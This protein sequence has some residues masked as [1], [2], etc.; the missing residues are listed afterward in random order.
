MPVVSSF[1][2]IIITMFW[3]EH[4][5]PPFHVSYGEYKAILL[6]NGYTLVQGWLPPRALSLVIEWA[7]THHNELIENWNRALA[8]QT[9]NK[10]EPL[11]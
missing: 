10:I 5:P 6:I 8:L 7:T 4:N 1:Y 11:K 2:G 3:N 9:I